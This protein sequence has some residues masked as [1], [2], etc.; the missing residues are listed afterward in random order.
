MTATTPLALLAPLRHWLYRSLVL[1]TLCCLTLWTGSATALT[2]T[3]TTLA[4]TSTSVSVGQST[5]LTATV[6]PS[7]ATG[8]V[9]FKDGGTTI[10]TGTLSAGVV[11]LATS[12]STVAVH[13]LT[14]VYA[15]SSI[16]ATSTSAAKNQTV[17]TTPTTT[18]LSASASTLY[19]GQTA[20]LTV[21]VSPSAATGTVTFKD[22]STVLGTGTLSAGMVTLNK[23]FTTT[24]THNLTA[25]Y[26]G[27][28]T[29]ATSTS[30]AV[31]ETIKALT[32]TTTTLTTSTNT[33]YVGQTITLTA[34]LNP[35][36]ATGTVTF[37]DG[38]VALGTGT[39]NAG[40]VTLST[41]FTTTGTHSLTATY[42]GATGYVASTST[43][44]TE[45]IKALTVTTTTLASSSTTVAMGQ[46]VTL[47]ASI[48]PSTAT[49]TVTFKDGST[50]LGSGTL[51]AGTVGISTIFTTAGS[52]SLTAVYAGTTGYTA[53]TSTAL[54]ETVTDPRVPLPVPP[55]STTPVVSFGYDAQNQPIQVV[56]APGVAGFNLTTSTTYDPLGRPSTLTDPQQGRT[57]L[58]YDGLGRVIA[59]TDPRNLSTQSPRDGLGQ[60]TLLQSPDTGSANLT[61]DLAG[62][63]LTRT[64]SRGVLASYLYDALNRVTGVSFALSGQAQATQNYTWTYD[65]TGAGFSNG[66]G[67][68]TTASFPEGSTRYAYDPQGRVVQTVQTVNAASGT[69]SQNIPHTTYYAYDAAGHVTS[70]IYPSGRTVSIS[71]TGG[72]PTGISLAQNA[73]ATAVPLLSSIQYAPFGAAQSWNWAQLSTPT[74]PQAYA[75]TF[76]TSGR[77]TRYPLASAQG[78]LLRDV[79]YDAANRITAYTHYRASVGATSAI[80]AP[81]LDQR[82][83]YDANSRLIQASVATA[84][85]VSSW[86]YTYDANGNRTSVAVNGNPPGAYTTASDSNRLLS[87]ATPPITLTYDAAGNTVSDGNYAL[88]YNLRGRLASVA[89]NGNLS[90]YSHDNA[91]Q[92]IRK[93]SNAGANSTVI[94]NYDQNGHLLGE[95]DQNGSAI[96]EYLWLDDQP[97]A[98]FTSDPS[99]GVN[100]NT[101]APLVYYVFAD[102]VNTPRAITDTAGNLRWSWVDEPFGTTPAISNPQGLGSFVMS[103][104]FPGQVYDP[105]SG[106]HYNVNRDYVPGVGRYAQSDPIGLGGGVNTYTYT[107]ANPIS[108]SDFEGLQ[109]DRQPNRPGWPN[110]LQPTPPNPNCATPECIAH[111]LPSVCE[112][113]T[114]DEIDKALDGRNCKMVCGSV[115]GQIVRIPFA[116]GPI[117]KRVCQ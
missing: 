11:K 94:F 9:T 40:A 50:T 75:R 96:R 104:R 51:S 84:S 80:P 116:R 24:G 88:G 85:A 4:L 71:Y 36:T 109:S 44:L 17:T 59:V 22:G 62:N 87:V 21:T 12:F 73:N 53:S 7:A 70:L 32:A 35:T 74:G 77:L 92:R 106:M 68:L 76:D 46:T 6:S 98:V 8:T 112:N 61:Y 55:S 48:I 29:Y 89:I 90:T 15:G 42:A 79:T 43:A 63:L 45:T 3:T 66:I 52:H 38:T 101:A 83:S 64:D 33:A 97:V 69:N 5:T 78:G 115:V 111:L 25:V 28:T 19:V 95:Y 41:S 2:A 99:Q 1:V 93:F 30:A 16:H 91:G 39:L 47:T 81:E 58:S 105:E 10:G 108:F 57:Q 65:Q 107:D 49:G 37:K 82:F 13:S 103:L 102:H 67:R 54:N 14:A 20:T 114:N 110:W 117:C 26:A 34:T 72:L 27:A 31:S 113:R 60:V 23:S 56:Q 86:A 18:V 100:A